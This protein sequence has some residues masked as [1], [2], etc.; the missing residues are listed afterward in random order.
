VGAGTRCKLARNLLHFIAFAA[1]GEAARL[2]EAAGIDPALLGEIARST[3]AVTGGPGA[4]L[5]RPSAGEMDD[6]DPLK[7]YLAHALHLGQKDLELAI[8]AGDE[9][10]VPTPL[11]ERALDLL[12]P[13]LGVAPL[14]ADLQ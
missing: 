14:P 13:A 4:I 10:G 1:A 9:L 3:D 11:A 2:A 12:G 6:A 5:I 7:P 8:A